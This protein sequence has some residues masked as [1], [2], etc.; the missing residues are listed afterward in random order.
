MPAILSLLVLNPKLRRLRYYCAWSIYAAILIMGS[1]PGARA[2]LGQ[3][4]SGLVL[5]A[6]AYAILTC[7]IFTGSNG[8]V[9][10]RAL[11][12]ILTVTLMGACDELIQNFFTYRGAAV[13][14]WL[15]DCSAAIVIAALL[16]VTSPKT[17]PEP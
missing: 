17:T 4:A 12:A 13:S 1:I 3:Y 10:R 11:G 6:L 7:L 15:V 2:E 9:R 5:H 16:W 8:N 14:V